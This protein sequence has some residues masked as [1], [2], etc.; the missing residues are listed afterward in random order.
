[1]ASRVTSSGNF[2]DGSFKSQYNFPLPFWDPMIEKGMSLHTHPKFSSYLTLLV[3]LWWLSGERIHLLRWRQRRLGFDPWVKKIPWRRKWQPTPVFL[4]EKSH[5]LWSLV[6]YSPKGCKKSDTIEH[7]HGQNFIGKYWGVLVFI[8]LFSCFKTIHL[9]K[10]SRKVKFVESE[11]T[12]DAQH[13]SLSEKCKLK[14]HWGT[15]TRQSEWLLSKSLQAI[16]AGEGVEKREHSYTVCGN[17][18]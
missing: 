7:E 2:I 13:H 9:Q 16:N 1:M 8:S 17:A 18:N 12:K 6:G 15:I 10:V 14:P 4:P 3:L 5:G 11:S